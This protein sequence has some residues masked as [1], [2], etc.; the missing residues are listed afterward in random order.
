[1]TAPASPSTDQTDGPRT[2]VVASR[3]LRSVLLWLGSVFTVITLLVVGFRLLA[4]V[5]YDQYLVTETIEATQLAGV[6][7]VRVANTAGSIDVVVSDRSDASVT[8]DVTDGLFAADRTV[9]VRS[10]VLR[11]ETSCD[12]WF[13]THCHVD[14]RLAVPATLPLE[15]RGRHGNV[16]VQGASA[17]LR[18]DGRF[19][20]LVVQGAGGTVS[21]DHGFG[22]VTATDLASTDV[23]VALRFGES[24]LGFVVAPSDVRVDSRFGSTT[25][26]VPDDGTVY[27]VTGTTSFGDRSI[28]VR[29]DPDS[30]NLIHVDSAFGEVT[31]R[32]AR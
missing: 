16:R 8:L 14:Q 18:V 11:V 3:R 1:M 21:I 6:G 5:A 17:A 2:P 25:I 13:A 29:T 23:D 19:G 20:D 26:E 22:A 9:G 12:L 24:T 4:Q 28:Q 7:Q 30:T 27:R 10:G 31:I 32:Y 15:V